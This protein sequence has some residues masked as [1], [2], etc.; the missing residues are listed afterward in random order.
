MLK[1]ITSES[2]CAFY[3]TMF[4]LLAPLTHTATGG[5]STFILM[6][7]LGLCFTATIY[8]AHR[9]R[10]SI[11]YHFLFTILFVV[12]LLF[13][14]DYM[15][16]PNAETS[17][18]LYSFFIYGAFTVFFGA[19]VIDFKYFLRSYSILAVIC[20]IIMARD[21]L[22][23]Y[24]WSHDYMEFGFVSML[25]AFAGAMTLFT[26]FKSKISGVLML[27]FF[28]ELVIFANKGS[29][30]TAL[31]LFVIG[32]SFFRNE[33]KIKL[34]QV[35]TFI[36]ILFLFYLYYAEVFLIFVK[37]AGD[38]G[39]D[40]YSLNTM[41]LIFENTSSNVVY[42][43][44]YEIWRNALLYFHEN[45]FLGC[46]IGYYKSISEGYEHNVLFEVLNSWGLIG[47]LLF[48]IV[49]FK[50]IFRIFVEIDYSRQTTIILFLIV[51]IVPLLTS[52]TFWA[53]QPFWAFITFSLIK[54]KSIYYQE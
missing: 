50:S 53:Y 2:I 37:I 47:G 17:N 22:Q 40:S 20:G 39:F 3:L 51:A 24:Q 11:Q 25:P 41:K 45:P 15:A 21:P 46:G 33:N 9:D 12:G 32:L 35:A 16:R 19:Q 4:S 26:V 8:V 31:I 1:Y 10:K 38:L 49:L 42:D 44:R 6:G 36:I 30:L 43:S 29:V 48:F 14:F 7:G 18:Y 28:V 27:L 5:V 23:D 54:S 13:C 34:K 52:L